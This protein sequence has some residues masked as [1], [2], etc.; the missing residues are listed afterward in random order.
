M[1]ELSQDWG[2]IQATASPDTTTDHHQA[3]Y[4][5][6]ASIITSTLRHVIRLWGQRDRDIHVAN[7][8]Q[9][10]HLQKEKQQGRVKAL[11][12][13]QPQ[14]RPSD[15][16]L[17]P[18]DHQ[19]F[20]TNSTIHQLSSWVATTRKAI[21]NSV[22]QAKQYA[23][24]STHPV[25]KWFTRIRAPP[26]APRPSPASQWHRDNLLHDPF[27]KKKR[28]KQPQSGLSQPTLFQYFTLQN[29]I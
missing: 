12:E 10:H 1:G 25:T 9:Q 27:S 5:W 17:S 19:E 23:I 13:L 29:I 11:L 14:C 20:L 6:S 15:H 4:L 16:V 8:A 28:H 21:W 7:A 2:R 22:A 18:D 3:P 26:Y 24:T